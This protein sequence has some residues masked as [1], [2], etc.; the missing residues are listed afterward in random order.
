METSH[1]QE[2]SR[3]SRGHDDG[4]ESSNIPTDIDLVPK[5]CVICLD[6]ISEQAV[7]LPCKHSDFDF[8]CLGSWLQNQHTCPL[9]KARVDGLE[10][11][12]DVPTGSKVFR[13]PPPQS[14]E[15][16]WVQLLPRLHDRR[17]TEYYRPRRK[18]GSRGCQE[19]GIDQALSKRRWV[20]STRSFSFHVGSNKYSKYR[21]VAPQSFASDR[22]LS[23]R[24]RKWIRREL[25][26]FDEV[27]NHVDAHRHGTGA[28]PVNAE[29]LLEYI[30]ALLR[31]T[32][33][34]ASTGKAQK[35]LGDVLGKD[36]AE[37]FLHELNS[38]LRSPYAHLVD[39][40]R[41]V[42]YE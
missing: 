37:L 36:Y 13:L 38:W 14:P 12:L 11:D 31:S 3:H 9:C 35:L 16:T 2:K 27:L 15:P 22:G 28:R 10:Y 40:D 42:Q 17:P 25:Q 7:A 1:I 23:D 21:D 30:I 4:F 41:A 26:V 8:A 33:I 19:A 5:T 39:W 34:R 18:N 24:A 32:D 29:F 6:K 20:Y